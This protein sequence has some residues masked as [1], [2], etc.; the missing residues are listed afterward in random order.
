MEKEQGIDLIKKLYD[1][2]IYKINFAG[3]EPLLNKHLSDYIKYSRLLGLK[4]SIITNAS[5]M[6]PGWIL[7]N[8]PNI[9]QVGISCDSLDDNVQKSIGR[10]FGNHVEVTKR[11]LNRIRAFNKDFDQNVRIKLNTVVM[12]QNYQEDWSDFILEHGVQ[13]WKMFKILLIKGE[14]DEFYEESS[15]TDD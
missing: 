3:G 12:R 1:F 2:G 9:D 5:R 14:N 7:K 15:I 13:R 10:G 4:V 8:C 6:T 11:A